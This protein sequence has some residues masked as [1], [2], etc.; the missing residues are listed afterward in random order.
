MEVFYRT[1]SGGQRPR[2]LTIAGHIGPGQKLCNVRRGV[3]SVHT[4][5]IPEVFGY[6]SDSERAVLEAILVLRRRDRVRSFGDADPVNASTISRYLRRPVMLDVSSLVNKDYVRRVGR[7]YDLTHTFNGKHRR[8]SWD[9]PALTVDTRFGDPRYFLHPSE[10]R[11]FS[12]SV[13]PT[14]LSKRRRW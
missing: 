14:H 5:D 10:N 7:S 4:W 1:F 9:T 11:G 12:V 13:R 6:A 3:R 8:L 2:A